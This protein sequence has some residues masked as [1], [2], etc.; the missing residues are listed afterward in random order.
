MDG[1]QLTRLFLDAIDRPEVDA[2]ELN[3]RAIYQ[4]LDTAA[5]EF[6]RQTRLLGAVAPLTTVAGIDTYD[7][8]PDFIGVRVKDRR[9]RLVIKYTAADGSVSWPVKTSFDR[10]YFA[11]ETERKAVPYQVAVIARGSEETRITGTVTTTQAADA[12][13]EALLVD[14]AKTFTG[15]VQARDRVHNTTR[16]ASGLALS[17]ASAH[18]VTCALFQG[19]QQGFTSGDAYTIAQASK[20]QLLLDAPSLTAGETIEVPYIRMPPPVFSEF[21][22][23]P[24]PESSCQAI[25]YEAAFHYLSNKDKGKPRGMHHEAFIE[26]LRQTRREIALQA[27]QS[28]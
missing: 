19:T 17:V 11:S 14:S 5:I 20:Y 24:F 8:P 21:A 4:A 28:R 6:A 13:G 10:I 27:L 26:E 2:L 16:Y 9:N 1:K 22:S 23:W 18:A 15:A 3:Q 25:A 7:L 12:G